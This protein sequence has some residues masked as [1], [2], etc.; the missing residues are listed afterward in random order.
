MTWVCCIEPP[1]D[2]TANV[3]KEEPLAYIIASHSGVKI[4]LTENHM[5]DF[6]IVAE[7]FRLLC[8]GCHC[9]KNFLLFL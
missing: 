5:E 3:S 6:G 2:S 9:E 8:E 1:H 7:M 4:G